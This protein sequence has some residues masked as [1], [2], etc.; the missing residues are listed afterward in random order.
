MGA[1]PANARPARPLIDG[2]DEHSGCSLTEREQP[3][4]RPALDED[5]LDAWVHVG[6]VA[7]AIGWRF[8]DVDATSRRRTIRPA[9]GQRSK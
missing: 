6:D 3:A 8:L 5:R 2:V 4:V 9:V 1:A 7:S